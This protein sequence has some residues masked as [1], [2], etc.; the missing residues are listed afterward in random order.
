MTDNEKQKL[1]DSVL[2]TAEQLAIIQLAKKLEQAGFK[3]TIT[4]GNL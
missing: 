2:T 1:I 3:L 4:V